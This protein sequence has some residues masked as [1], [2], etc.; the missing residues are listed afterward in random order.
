MLLDLFAN[1][2]RKDITKQSVWS[3]K[4]LDALYAQVSVNLLETLRVAK[5]VKPPKVNVEKYIRAQC[6][7]EIRDVVKGLLDGR[8]W[9]FVTF[10]DFTKALEDSS[11]T[12]LEV[13][14]RRACVV[15]DHLSKSSFWVFMLVLHLIKRDDAKK[16]LFDARKHNLSFLVLF[17]R[18]KQFALEF[19]KKLPNEC[20]FVFLDDASYSGEQVYGLVQ[21]T[22]ECWKATD[23]AR[24]HLPDV[25]III[26][27]MSK[28]SQQLL[29]KFPFT[30]LHDPKLI[31]N[32]FADRSLEDIF[33]VDL[34]LPWTKKKYITEYWSYLFSFLAL[35]TF[36]TLTF[37]EHKIP[38]RLSLPDYLLLA[39]P[40]MAPDI[41]HAYRVR[42]DKVKS[43]L[44]LLITEI[45]KDIDRTGSTL[46]DRDKEEAEMYY[47]EVFGQVEFLLQSEAFRRTY[48]MRVEF[49]PA[50]L[51][52]KAWPSFFPLID[53]SGM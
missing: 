51:E 52:G 11:Q 24:K 12:L 1:L 28:Q 2:F 31:G 15:I 33:L 53:P 22:S 29:L 34:F 5:R 27:Y 48:M 43:L 18:P 3:G 40:C 17:A 9:H 7:E 49:K 42:P 20:T 26:P 37:F 4:E 23:T 10:E 19:L 8:K 35:R 45:D 46:E 25:S 6:Y 50:K 41:T 30:T 14:K 38:D 39:G 32:V 13:M 16:K 47:N 36:Q 44:K 21:E